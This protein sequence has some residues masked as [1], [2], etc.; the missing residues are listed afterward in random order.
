MP[1]G[2][3]ALYFKLRPGDPGAPGRRDGRD[4]ESLRQRS[5]HFDLVSH[6]DGVRSEDRFHSA[7][8]NPVAL[9]AASDSRG[10]YG[11]RSGGGGRADRAEQRLTNG[12]GVRRD[13]MN[14]TR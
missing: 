8:P 14:I 10:A 7:E 12:R 13:G 5:S 11:A 9:E 3:G 6:A 1:S 2:T 4:R